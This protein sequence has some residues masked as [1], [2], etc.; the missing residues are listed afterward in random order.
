MSRKYYARRGTTSFMALEPAYPERLPADPTVPPANRPRFRPVA[1]FL[2]LASIAAL[3]I[4]AP[5]IAAATSVRGYYDAVAASGDP[6]SAPAALR[7]THVPRLFLP[8]SLPDLHSQLYR[9]F[10]LAIPGLAEVELP[11]VFDLFCI[12]DWLG[13]HVDRALYR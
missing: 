11:P 1:R 5:A 2:I 9:P 10:R 12:Q 6:A 13:S 7:P 4:V 3:L 8:H